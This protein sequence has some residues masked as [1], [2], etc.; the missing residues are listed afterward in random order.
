MN[1]KQRAI[2]LAKDQYMWLEPDLI[3]TDNESAADDSPCDGIWVE[4]R[5]YIRKEDLTDE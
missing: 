3:V 4:A 5:I 2:A 1:L